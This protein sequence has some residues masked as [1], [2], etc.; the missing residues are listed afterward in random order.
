MKVEKMSRKICLSVFILFF[1]IH[2]AM[3]VSWRSVNY[4]VVIYQM[5]RSK[6]E[7]R[8]HLLLLSVLFTLHLYSSRWSRPLGYV[9][10][11]IKEK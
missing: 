2:E 3:W 8:L 5:E 6:F 1:V 7:P 11:Q 9:N 4:N 10:G